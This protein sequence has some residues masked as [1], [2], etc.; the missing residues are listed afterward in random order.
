MAKKKRLLVD[1]DEVLCDFQTPVLGLLA[2]LFGRHMTPYDFDTWDIFATF[3][4]EE[5]DVVFERVKEPGFCM[6]FRPKPGAV[7]A[8]AE[9]RKTHYVTPVTR[10]FPSPTWVHDRMLWLHEHFG[11][12]ESEIVNTAAKELVYGDAML[13]DN[14]QHA[15]DWLATH[16]EG[17]AMLW[18]I[19][20]TRNMTQYDH[21]RVYT[22]DEVIKKVR[23]L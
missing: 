6:K 11:F 5:K 20:N 8:I 7:E 17:L 2:Q 23:A 13:D 3:S 10:P 21:L 14:P 1:V 22:W 4:K 16:P 18:H 9:I 12:R 15:T 19:P